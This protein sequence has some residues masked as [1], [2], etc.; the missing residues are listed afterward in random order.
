M[1]D[2]G[3]VVDYL[4]EGFVFV[5]GGGV[6]DVEEAVSGGGEEEGGVGWV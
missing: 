1:S 6:E 5:W 3:A 4:V 2:R